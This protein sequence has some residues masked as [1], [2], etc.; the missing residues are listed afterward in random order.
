MVKS[1]VIIIEGVEIPDDK[2]RRGI[3]P[4]AQPF[5]EIK[6]KLIPRFKESDL[7]GDEWRTSARI[8]FHRNGK[9]VYRAYY[10]TLDVA[11]YNLPHEYRQALDQAK[12]CYGG[13]DDYCDQ[14]GCPETATNT[15]RVKKNFCK[16]CGKEEEGRDQIVI[17]K[18]CDEHKKRGD[19]ALE[20]RDD[21]Y[22]LVMTQEE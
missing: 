5:D 15:F 16:T 9:E 20:D 8:S 19:C 7:S 18:F 2:V 4:G 12:G 17:R 1:G 11:V 10:T 21:N 22:E 3:K 6:I 14:E 13:E